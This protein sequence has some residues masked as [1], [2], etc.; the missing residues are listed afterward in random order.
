[1]SKFNFAKILCI[2]NSDGNGMAAAM[3]PIVPESALTG[4]EICFPWDVRVI[5]W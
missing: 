5:G 1:M 2:G 3:Q 4:G